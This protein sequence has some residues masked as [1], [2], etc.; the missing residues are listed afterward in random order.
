M[1]IAGIVLFAL[2]LTLGCHIGAKNGGF[3]LGTLITLIVLMVLLIAAAV[4]LI[5]FGLLA[6]IPHF[7]LALLLQQGVTFVIPLPAPGR[8]RYSNEA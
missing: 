5:V 4:I 2:G 3:P 8:F 1:L 6:T 7:H